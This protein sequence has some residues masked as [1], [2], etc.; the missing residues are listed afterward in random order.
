MQVTNHVSSYKSLFFLG[1]LLCFCAIPSEI[2]AQVLKGRVSNTENDPISG[3]TLLLKG[4]V[5]RATTDNQGIFSLDLSGQSKEGTLVVSSVGY[6]QKEVLVPSQSILNIVLERDL[7]NID[8]VVVIGYG[9]VA[10]RD[11]TGSVDKA[12]IKEMQKAPVVGFDQSL[13]GRVAGVNVVSSEGRPGAEADIII[14]GANSLTQNNNPLYVIDGFPVEGSISNAIDPKDI[15]SIEVLKDASATAIYGARGANGVVIVTTKKG[16]GDKASI[17]YDGFF[18]TQSILKKM[19]L[20]DGYEFVKLQG[21]VFG[22]ETME[23][24]YF[25]DGR[26]LEDYRGTGKDFQDD[27]FRNAL[28]QKHGL[29][30]MAGQGATKYD[31]S[32]SY[33][34]QDGVVIHT[35]F[36][37]IQGRFSLDQDIR[38]WLK[39]GAKVNYNRSRYMGAFLSEGTGTY[40]LIQNTWGY[41]PVT[42]SSDFDLENDLFDPILNSNDNYRINPI[43]AVKNEHNENIYRFFMSNAY[44]DISIWKNLKYRSIVGYTKNDT[45]N[46]IFNNSQS[47]SGNPLTTTLGVN[48]G[49]TYGERSNW[50]TENTLTFKQKTGRHSY[51]AMVGFSMQNENILYTNTRMQQIPYESLGMSGMDQGDFYSMN[52]YRNEWTL[53]S[54]YGR[55][56]YNY[57]GKYYFTGTM[58]GDG[59]SKFSPQN[60][61]GYFP[62]AALMWRVSKERFMKDLRFI[63]DAKIRVSWGATGN[64]R[65]GEYASLPQITANRTDRYYFGNQLTIGTA[66]TVMGNPELKWESTYMSNIGLDVNMFDSRIGFTAEVYNKRT[67]DLL[68]EA[69]LPGSSGYLTSFKNIGEVENRGLELTLN[70]INIKK[71]SFTWSSSFNISFNRNKVISLTENQQTLATSVWWEYNRD[72][73]PAYIA[74]IGEPVG[75]MFGFVYEGTYKPEEF[76]QTGANYYLKDNIAYPGSRANV[77]PGDMKYADLNGD[78]VIDGNDRTVIGNGFPTHLGGFNNT[79]TYRNFDLSIFFQWSYGNDILN[80]NTYMF[81][82]YYMPNSNMF[83]SYSERWTPENPMSEIPRVNEG[84]GSY[85]SSYGIEDGSYIRLKTLSVGYNIPANVFRNSFVNGIKMYVAAQNLWTWTN[86]TGMDPEVSTRPGA[87]TPGFDYSAYPRARTI[88]FGI[89]MNLK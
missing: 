67:K 37:R 6:K 13:A 87:L 64:N 78:G 79:F 74:R 26:T 63:N 24:Y 36:D 47:R 15:E 73:Q 82:R 35:D 10:K 11:L 22:P 76:T 84:S 43:I 69:Q 51:D 1:A 48:A 14:R 29:S 5:L 16:T 44:V 70:T 41:R 86:Y 46:D 49:Q 23:K 8:E 58:R 56:N 17:T 21:E 88:T 45:R 83:A 61:W 12:D 52:S 25:F 81:N 34:G 4:A 85:Y 57:D 75:L 54:F 42:G 71:P 30:I 66:K 3:A 55:A 62:S 9:T 39:V 40:N 59:S 7:V 89:N 53:M 18:G 50:L 20:M 72:S 31:L 2:Q 77:R 19:E 33:T 32:F 68:L 38:K 28:M 60:R 80:A 65:V 27:M